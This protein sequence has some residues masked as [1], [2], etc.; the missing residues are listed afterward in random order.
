MDLP[1]D[2]KAIIVIINQKKYVWALRHKC[3]Y[4]FNRKNFIMLCMSCHTKYDMTKE[5]RNNISKAFRGKKKSKET[6]ERMS[7]ARLGHRVTLKTRLK[8]SRSR[9]GKCSGKDN[10][11][12]GKHISDYTR[13]K[14]IESNIRRTG[15]KHNKPNKVSRLNMSNAQIKRFKNDKNDKN[16]KQISNGLKRY[17]RNLCYKEK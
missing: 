11:M 13:N 9:K 8:I 12:Y 3:K 15:T 5:W 16:R 7:K 1:T 4:E 6:L 2:V 14:V 10:C 17:Y